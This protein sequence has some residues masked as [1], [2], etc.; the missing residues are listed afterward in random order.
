MNTLNK[1]NGKIALPYIFSMLAIVILG[2]YFAVDNA[3]YIKEGV[4][5]GIEKG[6]EVQAKALAGMEATVYK[7]PNC[8]CCVGYVD[9]LEENG[10]SVEVVETDTLD[11]IKQ[12]YAV[13]EELQ[14]CHTV[15][16]G[17]YVVE[18]HMPITAVEKLLAEKP[19][20]DGI[21]L[22]GMPSGSPGMPGVKRGSFTVYEFKD[23]KKGEVFMML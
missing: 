2:W 23:G 13:P 15:L 5:Q 12:T 19:D 6:E 11:E 1:K 21:A 9:T 10:V 18:G 16:I 14:S 17:G 20:I 4:G 3:K 7:S 22:P 8:G